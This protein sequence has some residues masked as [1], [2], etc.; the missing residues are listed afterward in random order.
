[1]LRRMPRAFAVPRKGSTRK[2]AR[3][4]ILPAWEFP[5]ATPLAEM[6]SVA[7]ETVVVTPGELKSPDLQFLLLASTG[8]TITVRVL[9]GMVPADPLALLYVRGRGAYEVLRS[10]AWP[11]HRVQLTLA[12]WPKLGTIQY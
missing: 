12:A 2:V 9:R 8:D 6:V 1:M 3:D 10:E 11:M 4:I 7:R 5:R